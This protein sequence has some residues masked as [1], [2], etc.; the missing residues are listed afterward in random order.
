[1]STTYTPIRYPGG[2]TKIYN[3][4]S[5]IISRN[6]LT[7]C[8]YAEPF[9]GGSGLAI[10]LLLKGDVSRI[11]LN[12]LDRAIFCI[13]DAIINRSDELCQYIETVELSVD[14]WKKNREI[15]RHQKNVS[16][17]ELA[18]A[19]FYLNRTNVSGILKGGL[20]GGLEQT[21]SYKM[22]ARFTRKTLVKKIKNISDRSED[23]DIYNLDAIDFINQV[24]PNET[25]IFVYFDPP[26]VQKGPG[27]YKNSFD[28][29]AHC[30]LAEAIASCGKQWIVT[31][32][33]NEFISNLYSEFEQDD[34][35]IA[36]SAKEHRVGI[37]SLILS[38]GLS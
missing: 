27:L 15:Y 5:D 33:Q 35:K 32:D 6:S 36:Y 23:I 13:W 16:D 30:V 31:Y 1:M 38:P 18:K 17:F 8:T 10:K 4:M 11:I 12:D 3:T 21:G 37:E 25:N 9:A 28:A 19:A 2:K 20:I 26:Y 14:E 34:L 29:N 22:D 7:G 24:L